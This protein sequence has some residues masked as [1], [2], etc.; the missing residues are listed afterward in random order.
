[1]ATMIIDPCLEERIQADRRESGADRYDEV[2]E[3]VSV[4]SPMAD[5]EHQDIVTQLASILQIVVQW[6]GLGVAR[7]G[8]NISDRQAGWERNYRIPDV[9]VFLN[10]TSAKNLGTHWVGGPDLAIEV[11]SPGDQ[12]RAKLPFYGA[13][14]TRELWILDREPWVLEQYEL[15]DGA[16]ARVGVSTPDGTNALVSRAVPLSFRVVAGEPRPRIEVVH[17]EG[18]P[19]WT[20]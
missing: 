14:G 20:V 19:R 11:C 12:T 15:R 1:M 9:A 7:S 10:G 4:T 8:V 2:W 17:Q 18:N 5:D 13:I 6:A 16:M 3:G